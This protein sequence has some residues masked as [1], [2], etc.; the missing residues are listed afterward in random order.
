MTVV[1][2]IACEIF[3]RTGHD[4]H[5]LQFEDS[6]SVMQKRCP[7]AAW[8][9]KGEMKVGLENFERKAWESSSA[10]N[11]KSCGQSVKLWCHPTAR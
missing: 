10:P 3:E 8:L 5:V 4:D 1:G 2:R 7:L 11:I 9:K 6:N